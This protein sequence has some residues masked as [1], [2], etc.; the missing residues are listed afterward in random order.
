MLHGSGAVAGAGGSC[1]S[2]KEQQINHHAIC[3]LSDFNSVF[4]PAELGLERNLLLLLISSGSFE[5]R[6]NALKR[7]N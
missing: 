3:V 5:K 4:L 2:Q 6:I 7:Y 1:I